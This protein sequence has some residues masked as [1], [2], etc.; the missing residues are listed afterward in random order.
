MKHL[1]LIAAALCIIL[2]N[3]GCSDTESTPGLGFFP[4][5]RAAI[6]YNVNDPENPVLTTIF[7]IGDNVSFTVR[8]EDGDYDMATL[9]ATLYNRADFET[10]L[11][12]PDDV[13]LTKQTSQIM[14]YSYIFPITITG[15]A[16]EYS[17]DFQVEDA[18]GNISNV[19]QLYYTVE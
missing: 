3:F 2:I 15:P 11:S 5:I 1:R 13:P 12:G 7:E 18:R 9:W 8:A 14:T 6:S 4:K 10:P 19:Y 16:G 17:M